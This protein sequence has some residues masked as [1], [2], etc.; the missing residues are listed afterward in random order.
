MQ[1]S[2][3]LEVRGSWEKRK[4]LG[5]SIFYCCTTEEGLPEPFRCVFLVQEVCMRE[6]RPSR[7]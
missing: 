5:G 3:A 2:H 7:C 4:D 6:I 1:D